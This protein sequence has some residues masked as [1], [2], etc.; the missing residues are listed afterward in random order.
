V[1]PE[2]TDRPTVAESTG[3]DCRKCKGTGLF[4]NGVVVGDCFPCGGTGKR[5]RYR[6]MNDEELVAY[7]ARKYALE[8]TGP[9]AE[10]RRARAE[11]QAERRAQETE[12]T[13]N[14]GGPA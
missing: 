5:I 9:A 10:R 6:P 7:E 1:A 11:R 13:T 14:T 8:N 3:T 2:N 12:T 4:N